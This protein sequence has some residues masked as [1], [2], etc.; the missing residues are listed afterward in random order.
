MSAGRAIEL[1][2]KRPARRARHEIVFRATAML[3]ENHH[4]GPFA[5]LRGEPVDALD[6]AAQIVLRLAIEEPDLHIDDDQCVHRVLRGCASRLF[7][8]FSAASCT[9]ASPAA[10][11]RPPLWAGLPS[12]L[13]TTPP[14][15][16]T[17]GI[18]AAMS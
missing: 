9:R 6:D 15:P 3:H 5:Y 14:A 10:T 17:I 16:V 4:A 8:N 13:V 2:Q 7:N 18:R 11:M 12:Q 1:W